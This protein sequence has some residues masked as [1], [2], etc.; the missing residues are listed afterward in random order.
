MDSWLILLAIVVLVAAFIGYRYWRLHQAATLLENEDFKHLMRS[1]Q[2][3][4][5]R[6]PSAFNR[7]HILGARNIPQQ[8]LKSSLSALR[9]DK[10]VLLYENLRGGLVTNAAFLLKKHGFKEVYILSYG[11]ENWDGKVK[12]NKVV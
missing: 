9:K 11:L 3:I 2:L 6:D 4:D 8:Q 1:G 7:K 5:L 12:E 10:P